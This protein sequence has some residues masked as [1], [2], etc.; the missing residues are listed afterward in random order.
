MTRAL[1]FVGRLAR[2]TERAQATKALAREL[3]A[4]DL[5][6][7]VADAK[8]GT[9]VC[10]PG[11]P[12]LVSD[13]A[14]WTALL[15]E[16]LRTGRSEARVAFADDGACPASAFRLSDG[17]VLVTIGGQVK[18]DQL[19]ELLPVFPLLSA[20]IAGEQAA[21]VLLQRQEAELREQTSA[22]RAATKKLNE[23][24]EELEIINFELTEANALLAAEGEQA[25]QGRA[26]AERT[27]AHAERANRVKSDFLAMMSHELR[28]PL[29]AIGGYASLL[30]MGIAGPI[31]REQRTYIERINWSQKHL[32]TLINDVLNF[33]QLEAGKLQY[34]IASVALDDE[35]QGLGALV[36]PQA[37]ARS[38][39]YEFRPGVRNVAVLGDRDK[40]AQVVLNL[41]TNAVKFTPPGG[42]VV[43]HTEATPGE[44]LTRVTDSGPGIP[45]D[46]L[47][48]IFEPFVQLE[49]LL[50]KEVGGVGLGLA[51]SRE[52]AHGMHGRLIAE[53]E[54]GSGSTFTLTLPRA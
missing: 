14:G 32:A 20:A 22:L 29:N 27:R 2:M 47:E 49:R 36:E 48:L 16:C 40:I 37:R 33:A 52:L 42:S 7:F 9:L 10:A 5:I 24:R 21:S 26:E 6:L 18:A 51:I 19:T 31:T 8:R 43:L 35:L 4:E 23:T 45:A 13:P 44:V 46:R 39:A 11:F 17:S 38:V 53:S 3:G 34:H 50:T 30:E 15:D 1:E 28:T 25:E 41:L 12:Q 54:L